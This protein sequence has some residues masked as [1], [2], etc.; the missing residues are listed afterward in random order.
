MCMSPE[1]D[2]AE[3]ERFRSFFEAVPREDLPSIPAEL[4][5]T[6]LLTLGTTAIG[7]AAFEL[8]RADVPMRGLLVVSGVVSAAVV[9]LTR[10]IHT[11]REGN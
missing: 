1:V 5:R 10:L 4:G 6:A 3:A 11:P 7:K 8:L 9:G 2:T